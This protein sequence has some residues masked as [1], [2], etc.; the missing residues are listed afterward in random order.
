MGRSFVSFWVL[1]MMILFSF[2][3]LSFK[4]SLYF[5]LLYSYHHT[6]LLAERNAVFYDL[7]HTPALEAD[8]IFPFLDLF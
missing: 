5:S 8:S 4:C 2:I 7:F 6:F 1:S 3:S